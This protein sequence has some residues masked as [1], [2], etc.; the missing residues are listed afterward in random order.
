MAE[1]ELVQD[2]THSQWLREALQAALER[3]PISAANDAELLA[4]LLKQRVMRMMEEATPA[5]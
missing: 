3:D 4:C 5:A 2:E 1:M